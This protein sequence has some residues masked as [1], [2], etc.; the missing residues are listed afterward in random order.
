M[1][2]H[3]S[4]RADGDDGSASEF[5]F[6]RLAFGAFGGRFGSGRQEPW[7]RDWPEADYHFIQGLRRLTR[8]DSADGSACRSP[9]GKRL[10]A[11]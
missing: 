10:R 11:V 9:G 7:L 4:I 6:A 3:P 2:L 5:H 8:I 1:L